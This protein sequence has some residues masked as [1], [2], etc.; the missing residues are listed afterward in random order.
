VY[1][2]F[3]VLHSILAPLGRRLQPA[4]PAR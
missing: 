4:S 3:A 1:R 2:L